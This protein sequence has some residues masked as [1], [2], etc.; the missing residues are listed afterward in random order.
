M[1]TPA[2]WG[3]IT[4]KPNEFIDFVNNLSFDD[5][6]MKIPHE[7]IIPKGKWRYDQ[8]VREY[9]HFEEETRKVID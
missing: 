4:Y 5:I 3:I 1:P 2:S 8:G 9:D 6:I 7:L